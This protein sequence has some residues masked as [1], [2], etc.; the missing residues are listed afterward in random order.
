MI[1]GTIDWVSDESYVLRPPR[2]PSFC[3]DASL[4][5]KIG[6][7]FI[8]IIGKQRAQIASRL[9][10]GMPLWGKMRIRDGGDIF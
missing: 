3:P 5:I 7:Y 10:Q 2:R 4:R 6:T 1:E 9:P 8:S